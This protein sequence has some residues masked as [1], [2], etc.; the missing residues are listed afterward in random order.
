MKLC[1]PRNL[2]GFGG[3]TVWSNDTHTYC[4][5]INLDWSVYAH[6]ISR[7]T[8]AVESFD[9]S[10]IS[11][12]PLAVPMDATSQGDE[13]F[14]FGCAL[15]AQD[16]FHIRGNLHGGSTPAPHN[17]RYVRCD[18]TAAFTTAG[19]WVDA[20]SS[21]TILTDFP[22][23]YDPQD[24]WGYT[25]FDGLSDGTLLFCGNAERNNV[26]PV[27]DTIG[28][29][30]HLLK[31]GP[32]DTTWTPL[33]GDGRLNTADNIQ[34]NGDPDRPYVSQVYVDESDG[35]HVVGVWR[36]LNADPDSAE[37]PWYVR[38]FDLG[39]TWETADGTPVVTW[40]LTKTY[41]DGLSACRITSDQAG[42]GYGFAYVDGEP[43][44][45]GI[46]PDA[47]IL[48]WWFDG[49]WQEAIRSGGYRQ[50]FQFEDGIW[51]VLSTQGQIRLGHETTPGGI[52]SS[53]TRRRLAA[54]APTGDTIPNIDPYFRRRGVL[55]F[56]LPDG[57]DNPVRRSL[58]DRHRTTAV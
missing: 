45:V 55:A 47:D 23:R 24:P 10:T 19:S 27:P 37:S 14:R 29:E 53:S 40:P 33:F 18:N 31:L 43:H 22:G 58:G 28:R 6:R 16:R 46:N 5:I 35:I 48:H 39:A 9:L 52:I 3:P 56:I 32:S 51:F 15:D 34:A 4:V 12:N 42:G 57:D 44:I 1:N 54:P 25:M 13:H 21:I 20:S 38:S 17:H 8:G 36:M 30:W 41:A 11:G 7:A 50:M 2:D 49:S 26:D